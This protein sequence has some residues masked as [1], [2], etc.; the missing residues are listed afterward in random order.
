MFAVTV[1]ALSAINAG[2]LL[3]AIGRPDPQDPVAAAFAERVRSVAGT[4][5]KIAG[6]GA[7]YVKYFADYPYFIS[8][9]RTEVRYA[10]I[11]FDTASERDYWT[12]KRPDV[13]IGPGPIPAALADYVSAN[14]LLESAPGVWSRPEGCAE[15]PDA[16]GRSR[17]T[18]ISPAPTSRS[19]DRGTPTLSCRP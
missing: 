12:R 11:Y 5:C 6:D 18:G 14:G 15:A 13:V 2:P 17:R 1:A 10:M 16:A 8:T 4:R 9:R 19:A 7:L 3:R